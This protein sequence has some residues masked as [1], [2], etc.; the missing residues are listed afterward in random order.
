MGLI[1]D[2][3][4]ARKRVEVARRK[5]VRPLTALRD[6]AAPALRDFA[7]A[8]RGPG[9][10]A[11]AEVKRRSPS[12]GVLREQV[13]PAALA[14]E[15]ER[16]GAA[17]LSVLTDVEYFGGR[18]E[19]L[20][21]ARRATSLPV[22]RKD[23]TVDEYQI[24]EARR[25][26]ADAVLLIVRILGDGELNEFLGLAHELGLAALVEVHDERELERALA[27]GAGLLGVNNRDLG[28]LEVSLE[29]ALRLAREIPDDCLSVAE[30]GVRTRADVQRLEQAGYDAMLVGET[31]LRSSDPGARLRGLLGGG[32]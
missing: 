21:A 26:G 1:I 8:L 7:A 32:L 12:G 4:V 27:A 24:H 23:F 29:T 30:S 14:G 13:D 2:D 5:A 25:L 17:A 28:T 10:A 19:D 15:Y 3:I 16:N 31:L 6:A 18:D 20:T 22:L 11:I 9:V